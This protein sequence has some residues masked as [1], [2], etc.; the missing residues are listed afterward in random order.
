MSQTSPPVTVA[1]GTALTISPPGGAVRFGSVVVDNLSPFVLSLQVSANQYWQAPWSSALYLL[2]ETATPIQVIPSNVIGA[3]LA[4][5]LGTQVQGTWYGLDEVPKGNW[6]VSLVANAQAAAVLGSVTVLN[7]PA[8]QPV[9]GS[10]AVSNFPA[11]VTVTEVVAASPG[12]GQT[13]AAAGPTRAQL[14]SVACARGLMVSPL[15]G[16][17]G[18]VYIGNSAVTTANGLE[19][20]QGATPIWLPV[21][22]ANRLYV[23]AATAGWGVSYLGL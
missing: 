8:T 22:N 9:S 6:P 1:A 19:I 18:S 20:P 17:G 13:V 12:T 11:L 3:T 14:A 7:F 10:V 4:T 15:A 21:D 2:G 23:T 5:G 16:N